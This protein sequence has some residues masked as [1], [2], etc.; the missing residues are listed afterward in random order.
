MKLFRIALPLY[1]FFL[2]KYSRGKGYGKNKFVRKTMHF[3]DILFRNNE[4]E[5]HG[6]AA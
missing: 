5:V 2:K 3:F 6:P 4:V 1:T